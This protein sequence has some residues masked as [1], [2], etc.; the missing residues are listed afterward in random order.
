VFSRQ[1]N[2]KAN[3]GSHHPDRN[4]QFEHINAKVV[5]AQARRQPVIS[6][7]TKK[8]EL[9]GNFKIGGTDFRPKGDPRRV[10]S[11]RPARAAWNPWA[12][13]SIV[14][15]EWHDEVPIK[16]PGHY[17]DGLGLGGQSYKPNSPMSATKVRRDR[18]P[19]ALFCASS[20]RAG[21][22]PERHLSGWASLL[23]GSVAFRA[24]LPDLRFASLMNMDFATSRP[25]VQRSRLISGSCPSTCAFAPRFLQT[26][27]RGDSP[28]HR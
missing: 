23:Q 25:L 5:A 26:P 22:H 9:L 11:K 6:V 4:A 1:S 13:E 15:E 10:N 20:D 3:E 8:K 17:R 19:A 14:R 21:E 7:D 24:Q 2:R 18:S 12:R 27:P 28:A 16:T